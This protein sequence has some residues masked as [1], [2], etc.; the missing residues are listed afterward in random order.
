VVNPKAYFLI[1]FLTNVK[2]Y[3]SPGYTGS[4][5]KHYMVTAIVVMLVMGVMLVMF[6]MCSNHRLTA[7]V[8]AKY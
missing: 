6:I 2:N 3:F 4:V 8:Y 1:K 7:K 5:N